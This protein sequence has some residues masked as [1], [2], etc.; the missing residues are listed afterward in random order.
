MFGSPRGNNGGQIYNAKTES[1]ASKQTSPQNTWA[2]GA[3]DQ[4]N[5]LSF[6]NFRAAVG[7]KKHTWKE[8]WLCI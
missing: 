4:I 3:L 6:Q 7:T 5:S 2:V 8:I 1:S